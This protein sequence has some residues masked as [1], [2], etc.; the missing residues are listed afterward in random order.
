MS[1][2]SDTLSYSMIRHIGMGGA[3]QQPR[4]LPKMCAMVWQARPP[5]RSG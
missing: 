2:S 3:E 5:C 4:N 1:K